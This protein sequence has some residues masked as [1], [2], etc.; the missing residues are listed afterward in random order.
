[1]LV[2]LAVRRWQPGARAEVPVALRFLRCGVAAQRAAYSGRTREAT[3]GHG[4][5]REASW[6]PP[7][8]QFC[9]NMFII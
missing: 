3:G 5:P 7:G 6:R 2:A 9:K 1:M 4:R 8:G